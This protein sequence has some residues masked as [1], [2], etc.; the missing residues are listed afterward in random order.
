MGTGSPGQGFQE[1]RTC[2]L[3]PGAWR[4]PPL[5]VQSPGERLA[6]WEPLQ[7]GPSLPEGWPLWAIPGRGG[8]L[9]TRPWGLQDGHGQ[10]RPSPPRGSPC[11]PWSPRSPGAPVL[12]AAPEKALPESSE[13][14]V[15]PPQERLLGFLVQDY[16]LEPS[17]S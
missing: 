10:A 13:P 8:N 11:F 14:E 3:L 2:V 15:R 5:S 17:P 12:T 6:P 9:G 1:T 7:R 16:F 4:R